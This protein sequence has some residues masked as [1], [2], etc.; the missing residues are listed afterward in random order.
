MDGAIGKA[1]RVDRALSCVADRLP[2]L[3]RLAAGSRV[4]GLFEERPIERVGFVE[5]RERLETPVRDEA[6]EGEFAGSLVVIGFCMAAIVWLR[7][8]RLFLAL[9]AMGI[10]IAAAGFA[11]IGAGYVLPLGS[12]LAV[13]LVASAIGGVSE[14][15]LLS[16]ALSIML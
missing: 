15:A 9:T 16:R 10:L 3:F 4:D 2:H 13:S 1:N 7:G 6:F 12:F 5:D 8:L 14:Y 11:S